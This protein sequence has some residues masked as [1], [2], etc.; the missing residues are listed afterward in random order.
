MLCRLCNNSTIPLFTQRVL[1]RYDVHY[2]CCN[3]C[4]LIQSEKPYWLDEAYADGAMADA[5]TGAIA[6]NAL[7]AQTTSVIARLLMLS[8]HSRCADFGGGHGVFVRM[9]RDRGMD[10][11]LCDKYATNLFARGFEADVADRFEL[12]TA[13]EV[14]EHFADPAVEI[15]RIFSPGHDAVLVGTVLHR[16]Y[17]P[18]WWYFSPQTGQHVAIYSAATMQ[19]IGERR[20]YRVLSGPAY[21]LFLRRDRNVSPLETAFMERLLRLSKPNQN[22]KLTRVMDL[23][24]PRLKSR[25]VS[26]CQQ[27]IRKAA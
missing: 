17:R 27:V 15:E 3:V 19:T 25:V 22:S 11:R 18:G 13:F 21:T 7:C 8:S 4:D 9:M 2:F 24:L 16:G 26:D 14:F 5:D 20:G 23:L 6:R 1:G 10:F 12:M